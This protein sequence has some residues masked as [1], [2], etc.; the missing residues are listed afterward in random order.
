V[1]PALREGERLNG[2][3]KPHFESKE[4]KG[5]RSLKN[6]NPSRGAIRPVKKGKK[7]KQ[8]IA[9][10]TIEAKN[11]QK[12]RNEK[13]RLKV[14]GRKREQCRRNRQEKMRKGRKRRKKTTNN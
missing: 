9:T 13:P 4:K 5:K 6:K 3:G 1:D 14:K 2:F 8:L 11:R 7:E 10:P 12:F